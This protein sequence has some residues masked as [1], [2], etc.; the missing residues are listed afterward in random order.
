MKKLLVILMMAC[1]ITGCQQESYIKTISNTNNT[2]EIIEID[3]YT[4]YKRSA[5][6]GRGFFAPTPETIKRC[7]REVNNEKWN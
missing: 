6:G 1:I 7:L 3:G 5:T 4:Y 2:Y